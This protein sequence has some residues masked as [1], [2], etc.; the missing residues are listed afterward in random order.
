V[1]IGSSPLSC[2][3]F[4]PLLLL[5]AFPL[6]IAG[7][8]CCSCQPACLFT[9]HVGGE[10]SPLSCDVFLPPP[11]SQAFLLLVV[12]GVPPL[13]LEPLQPGLVCL[14][15]VPG[16]IP[17]PPLWSSGH[18]TLFALC[19]YCSYCLLFNFSFFP[20][21]GSDCPGGYADLAQGC[22]W[23]YCV[24]L[25]SPCPCPHLPKLSGSG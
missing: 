25:S 8:C 24:P 9:A 4:L 17:L 16:R 13:P 19:L 23:E 12:G 14:F 6:L 5:Q 2:G 15:T 1:G 10:S 21:W 22:L 18:P 11:L 3:V 20:G 7:W